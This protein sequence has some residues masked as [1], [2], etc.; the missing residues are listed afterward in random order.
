METQAELCIYEEQR[1]WPINGAR[2]IDT[3]HVRKKRWK[4]HFV[5]T[6]DIDLNLKIKALRNKRCHPYLFIQQFKCLLDCY[7]W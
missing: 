6:P 3:L 1:V 4:P 7:M 5:L 2:T